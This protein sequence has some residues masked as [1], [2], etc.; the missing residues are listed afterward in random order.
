MHAETIHERGA[1]L[2]EAEDFDLGSLATEFEH[3]FVQGGDGSDIPAVG[4]G[5]VDSDALDVLF[6]VELLHEGIRGG[7][8][9]LPMHTVGAAAATDCAGDA[10]D[11]RDFPRKGQ[12]TEQHTHADSESEIVRK[13]N[14]GDGAEHDEAGGARMQ[15][16]VFKGGPGE[17]S[18]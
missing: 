6:E 11:L 8:E 10:H 3:N 9:Y 2:I 4:V 12:G 7:K 17:G 14:D 13:D 1:G 16:H 18:D 15:A 5:D